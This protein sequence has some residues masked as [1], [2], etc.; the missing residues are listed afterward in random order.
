MPSSFSFGILLSPLLSENPV[1]SQH[2]LPV[3]LAYRGQSATELLNN[4]EAPL[5]QHIPCHFEEH[6]ILR[7]EEAK[8][9]L[10]LTQYIPTRCPDFSPR[11]CHWS[12]PF[13]L[14]VG[15]CFFQVSKGQPN[16]VTGTLCQDIKSYATG[17]SPFSI[18]CSPIYSLLLG[19]S[20]CVTQSC[21]SFSR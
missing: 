21:S 14:N 13:R 18:Q 20:V 10:A 11:V 8:S 12:P 6:F 15:H 3:V 1:L 7:T 9:F 19:Q 4:T 2:L 17:F 16:T 5:N